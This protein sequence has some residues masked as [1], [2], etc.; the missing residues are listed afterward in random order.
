MR[1]ILRVTLSVA[2]LSA[3]LTLGGGLNSATAASTG[4]LVEKTFGGSSVTCASPVADNGAFSLLGH[5]LPATGKAYRVN[6]GTFPANLQTGEVQ[7][8]IDASFATWDNA[9]SQS[10][11]A[12]SGITSARPGFK[13]GINAVG[14]GNTKSGVVAVA[15][16]WFAKN[17]AF[18]EFDIVLSNSFSWATNPAAT[19][20]CGGAAGTFD[21]QNIVT[22]EAGHVVGLADLSA[23]AAEAQTMFGYVAPQELFKRTLASGDL[24][25]VAAL[26][27]AASSPAA[28]SAP[29]DGA[30]Q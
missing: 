23:G 25:G 15:Y 29:T 14:F 10:L 28:A 8:A 6:A 24:K 5:K 12:N 2:I 9:T 16:G 22:H 19:G 20:D 18:A 3:A 13:D 11:F 7:A 30:L 4:F 1:N 21:V 27:G 17:G 26:Y